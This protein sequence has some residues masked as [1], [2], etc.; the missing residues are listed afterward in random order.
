M[1]RRSAQSSGQEGRA[2][3]QEMVGGGKDEGKTQYSLKHTKRTGVAC[4]RRG[5]HYEERNAMKIVFSF[6]SVVVNYLCR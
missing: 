4:N 6:S 1:C 3:Y 5:Q 2:A